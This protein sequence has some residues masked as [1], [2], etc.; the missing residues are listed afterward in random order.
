MYLHFSFFTRNFTYQEVQ[1]SGD[2]IPWLF[3]VA[4]LI[5]C[6]VF[7]AIFNSISVISRW[8][9]HLSMLFW[10]SFIQYSIFFSTDSGERGMDPVAMTIIDIWKEYWPSWESNQLPPVVKSAMLPTELWGSAW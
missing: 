7:N 5:D 9:V 2:Q 4:S 3:L 1:K 8:P 10:S 6:M